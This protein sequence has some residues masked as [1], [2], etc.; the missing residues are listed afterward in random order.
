MTERMTF[1]SLAAEAIA[2]GRGTRV[3]LASRVA[4]RADRLPTRNGQ[5]PLLVERKLMDFGSGEKLVSAFKDLM[6]KFQTMERQLDKAKH[7][8]LDADRSDFADELEGKI[9]EIEDKL[10]PLWLMTR[11]LAGDIDSLAHWAAEESQR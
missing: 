8:K 6:V 3:E 2:V 7:A 9:K 4:Q 5:P 10:E 11:D 1:A